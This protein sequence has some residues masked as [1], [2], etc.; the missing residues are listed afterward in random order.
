ML[1][2]LIALSLCLLHKTHIF[3][4]ILFMLQTM[5]FDQY[6][7]IKNSLKTDCGILI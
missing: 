7:I 6:S 5:G 1:Y 3:K 2:I 4:W